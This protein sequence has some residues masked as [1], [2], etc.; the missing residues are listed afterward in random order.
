MRFAAVLGVAVALP[1]LVP[2]HA[3]DTTSV[4]WAKTAESSNACQT[5]A[6]YRLRV[7]PDQLGISLNTGWEYF[8]ANAE[9]KIRANTTV[10]GGGS[11]Q[12]RLL[13]EAD[14]KARTGRV[15]NLGNLGCAWAGSF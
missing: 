7:Q 9:G 14:L 1:A 10:A 6:R 2:A 13:I 3:Q 12:T 15:T 8:K 4:T 5:E 11:G